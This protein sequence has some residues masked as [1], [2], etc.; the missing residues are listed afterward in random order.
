MESKKG[1]EEK[2]ER[3]REAY[4]E[5][6]KEKEVKRRKRETEEEREKTNIETEE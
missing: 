4:G 6:E 5:T 1:R 2:K 3:C